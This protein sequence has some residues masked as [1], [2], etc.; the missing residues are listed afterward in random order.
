MRSCY[1]ALQALIVMGA[2]ACT[3]PMSAFAPPN[4]A[5]EVATLSI[6]PVDL[7]SVAIGRLVPVQAVA[8][9]EAGALVSGALI[10]WTISDPDV[11]RMFRNAGYSGAIQLVA[12]RAGVATVTATS[13]RGSASVTITVR[14]PGP[15]A[16]L[17][18]FC[19]S[20]IAL[21]KTTQLTFE[22]RDSDGVVLR[23]PTPTY[24]SSDSSIVR[25]SSTGL[26]VALAQG[27]ATVTATS[28]G[29][30]AVKQVVVM[31]PE[32]AFMWT[33]ATGMLDLETLPGFISSRAMAV[34]PAGHVAG[35]LSTIADSL[36]R[37]FVRA[38]GASGTMRDLAGFPGGGNSEAFGVNSAGQVIGYAATSDGVQHAVL[39]EAN[40]EM[41]VLGTLHGGQ[42]VALGINDAGQVVG[43]TANGSLSQPFMWTV[44]TGMRSMPGSTYGTAYAINQSG[45]V[46]G[47]SD[48]RPVLW[49]GNAFPTPLFLLSRDE[50]GR[51]LAISRT[52]QPVGTS[53]GCSDDLNAYYYYDDCEPVAHPV[54]WS[55]T[56]VSF[57]LRKGS[58]AILIASAL[59]INSAEQVVGS[60]SLHRA[61]LWTRSGV[62]DL[63]VL[64]GRQ[65]SVAT[66]INDAG[67]VVGSSLNP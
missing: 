20:A 55:G 19:D 58:S 59:G 62:R 41:R 25:V 54:T 28:N 36:L 3:D 32:H 52:G 37:A 56:N 30:R 53:V 16:T 60:S 9:D 38:P 18:I 66:A 4:R 11:V 39:W 57:D 29:K 40:G 26:L 61:I 31:A 45:F 44:A 34:S 51:A 65:W 2:V 43:R 10:N 50:T 13:G 22:Q 63:G 64:P 33:A 47:E 21:G 12:E 7:Q 27:T 17:S 6:S 35:T 46:V 23:A 8:R 48:N 1:G 42:S 67:L 24:E 14:A 5:R 49:N 15:V